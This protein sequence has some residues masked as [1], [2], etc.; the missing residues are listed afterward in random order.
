MLQVAVFKYGSLKLVHTSTVQ[1]IIPEPLWPLFASCF[2]IFSALWFIFAR[3]WNYKVLN[4]IRRVS[5]LH[6]LIQVLLHIEYTLLWLWTISRVYSASDL[7]IFYSSSWGLWFSFFLFW[8]ENILHYCWMVSKTSVKT[9]TLMLYNASRF[10]VRSS[11][12]HNLLNQPED[13]QL[14]SWW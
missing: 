12:C 14:L 9:E 11:A 10:I 1:F 4:N 3:T 13:F 7:Q 2:T 8:V 5:A 6:M